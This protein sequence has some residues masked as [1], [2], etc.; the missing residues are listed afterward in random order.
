MWRPTLSCYGC[1][2]ESK[3]S[4][5]MTILTSRLLCGLQPP[6]WIRWHPVLATSTTV[7]VVL[8]QGEIVERLAAFDNT[9]VTAAAV[10]DS[11]TFCCLG[12][13]DGTL[14]VLRAADMQPLLT[15]RCSTGSGGDVKSEVKAV[16]LAALPGGAL[17]LAAAFDNGAVYTVDAT[18]A[19]PGGD[20]VASSLRVAAGAELP[21]GRQDSSATLRHCRCAQPQLSVPSLCLTLCLRV[22]KAMSLSHDHTLHSGVKQI[23]SIAR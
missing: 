6:Q 12:A 21:R 20:A 14:H 19:A 13:A 5:S 10:D 7:A 1:V 16:A 3:A 11:G 15:H 8:M 9:E 22:K 4:C 17:A 18:A 23:F 2:D